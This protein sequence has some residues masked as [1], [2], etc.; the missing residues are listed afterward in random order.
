MSLYPRTKETNTFPLFDI[1]FSNI[2]Y[3]TVLDYGGNQ[4][5]LLYFSQGKIQPQHYTCVDVDAQ[6]IQSG[7]QEFPT[8]TW[9]HFN[10]YNHAYNPKG[11]DNI[12][13]SIDPSQDCIYAF[14]IFTHTDLQDLTVTL[15]WFQTLDYKKIAVSLLDIKNKD[16][17]D[18]FYQKRIQTYGSCVDIQNLYK[19]KNNCVYLINNDTIITDETELE[20]RGCRHLLTFYNLDFIVEYLH[21]HSIDVYVEKPALSQVPFI[22]IDN[23]AK[24]L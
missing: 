5:N 18:F 24:L 19:L 22:C 8:S 20:K 12:F 10:R 11:K 7:Q 13:P 21:Q 1:L 14:S 9:T 6:S 16:M 2:D 17:L 4:G 23:Q 3:N 15:K